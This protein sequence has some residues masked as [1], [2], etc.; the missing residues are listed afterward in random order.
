MPKVTEAHTEARTQQ[1]LDAAAACF[2]QKGFH[3]T[4]MHDICQLAELSPGAVYRYFAGKEEIIEAMIRGRHATSA[5]LVEAISGAGDTQHILEALADTFF[6]ELDNPNSCAL[7]IE[8]WAEALRS[9]R[10]RDLLQGEICAIRRPFTEIIRRAQERGEINQRLDAQ[11][12][13]HVMISFFDGLVLQRAADSEIDVR[14]YVAAMK[15][16]MGG[17]FWRRT[18]EREDTNV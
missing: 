1:I 14:K 3:H 12:I 18:L 10:I 17:S 9:E 4:T 7:S 11:A 5:A 6:A 2:A 16:M 15:A 8:L 13:A